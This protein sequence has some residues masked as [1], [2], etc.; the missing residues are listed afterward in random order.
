MLVPRLGG[1]GACWAALATAIVFVGLGI[2]RSER[3]WHIGFP[4]GSV[5]GVALATSGTCAV[6]LAL[7]GSRNAPLVIRAGGSV[8]L[9]TVSIG[10]WIAMLV[11]TAGA[12]RSSAS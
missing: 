4:V 5:V 2:Q 1:V 3:V 12:L 8:V 9:V 7:L 10:I 11:R 6:L